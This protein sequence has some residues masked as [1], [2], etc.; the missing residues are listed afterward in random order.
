[1]RVDKKTGGKI[2]TSEGLEDRKKM[3]QAGPWVDD[4][5]PVQGE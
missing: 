2:V 1:M 3:G 4:H 5:G